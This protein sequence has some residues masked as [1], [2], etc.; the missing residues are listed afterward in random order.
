MPPRAARL[1]I[2]SSFSIRNTRKI[3]KNGILLYSLCLC[4]KQVTPSFI[5]GASLQTATAN[6]HWV[7]PRGGLV[8]NV[9]F[10]TTKSTKS[11]KH[12]PCSSV[13]RNSVSFVSGS[14]RMGS[15]LPPFLF[16][17]GDCRAIAWCRG[18]NFQLIRRRIN[19]LFQG[20]FQSVRSRFNDRS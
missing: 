5:P 11:T 16:P 18:S 17:F 9:K 7:A 8:Y 3:R 14:C 20:V 19:T 15:N 13:V 4:E 12:N 1:S 6:C 2:T 10:G